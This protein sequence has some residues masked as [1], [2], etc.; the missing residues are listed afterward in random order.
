MDN[1]NNLPENQPVVA[2][3][4]PAP[5]P[6]DETPPAPQAKT[7]NWLVIS[8]I[9][10]VVLLAVLVPVAYI[11]GKQSAVTDLSSTISTGTNQATDEE[12]EEEV[13]EETMEDISDTYKGWVTFE[14]KTYGYSFK[15]PNGW[16]I[17]QT[18]SSETGDWVSVNPKSEENP[19]SGDVLAIYTYFD[20][21]GCP[22]TK[23][24]E[25]SIGGYT[26]E[27]T[28]CEGSEVYKV[29]MKHSK[30]VSRS[31]HGVILARTAPDA[32]G[33]QVDMG[34]GEDKA[35]RL[36]LDSVTGLTP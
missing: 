20:G 2:P 33:I 3:E 12:P 9:A 16:R 5:V 26:V 25:F 29:A 24:R 13:T 11:M 35:I 27:G 4:Q 17:K 21:V 10:A 1:Q 18:A 8:L 34:R 31:G 36:M 22:T 30:T 23:T 6:L 7:R 14:N 19:G 15:Y 32:V 28:A